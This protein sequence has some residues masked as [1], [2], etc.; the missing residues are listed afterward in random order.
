MFE[1]LEASMALRYEREKKK[2][3]S[4]FEPSKEMKINYSKCVTESR[5]FFYV[6][7][8]NTCAQREQ[9]KIGR[10]KSGRVERGEQECGV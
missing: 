2:M 9:Q 10:M 5:S 7:V 6:T 3:F 1:I 4:E 8:P